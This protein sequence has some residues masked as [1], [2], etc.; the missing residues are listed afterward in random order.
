[1]KRLL[2]YLAILIAVAMIWYGESRKFFCLDNGKC[3]TVWKTYDDVCYIIPGRYYGIFRPSDNFIQSSNT[4]FLTIYFT[5]E[6]P[7]LLVYK[8]EEPLKVSNT[9]KH[10]WIFYDYKSNIQKFDSILYVANAKRNNDIKSNARLM[11]I[12][13]QENYALDKNGKHL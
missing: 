4:N 2:F 3:V 11:D 9:N 6:L 12:F 1:M 7:N 8:S 10:K 13:I 5:G